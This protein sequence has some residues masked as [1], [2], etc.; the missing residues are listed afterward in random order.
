MCQANSHLIF[1]TCV[2]QTTNQNKLILYYTW[3]L[4]KYIGKN[5]SS[6]RGKIVMPKKNLGNGITEERI[7]TQLNSERP[8]FDFNYI[9]SERDSLKIQIKHTLEGSRYFSLIFIENKWQSGSNN[10]FTSITENIAS[11]RIK[12][13]GNNNSKEKWVTSTKKSIDDLIYDIFQNKDSWKL[14]KELVK[15]A[16]ELAYEKGCSSIFNSKKNDKIIGIS[17]L[18]HLYYTNYNSKQI[19]DMFLELLKPEEDSEVITLLISTLGDAELT[20]ENID[21]LISFKNQN[22]GVKFALIDAVHGLEQANAIDML[23]EFSKDKNLEIRENA[24]FHLGTVLNLDNLSIRNALWDNI[25]NDNSEIRQQ[26][27]YGLAKRKDDRIT[28]VLMKEIEQLDENSFLIF[29]AI[30]T[31]NDKRLIPYLENQAQNN[32]TL[33]NHIQKELI[34]TL[35]SLRKSNS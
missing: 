8:S 33:T 21:T 26:A 22:D 29:D 18:S 1:C 30:R 11:G 23:L 6:L 15:R 12:S 7:L 27:I 2:E 34:Q 9:P 3:N 20:Q 4:T 14:I 10:V 13:L 24:V 28:T 31:L 19:I 25:T 17:I 5:K 32:K 35:D 16:P